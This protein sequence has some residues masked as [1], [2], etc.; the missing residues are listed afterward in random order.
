MPSVPTVAFVQSVLPE[1]NQTGAKPLLEY[2][3]GLDVSP[4]MFGGQVGQTLARAGDMLARNAAA[5]QALANET[6]VN[7][8][9]SNGFS[10]AFRQLRENFLKLEGKDA[11]AQFPSY[12]QQAN[13]LSQQYR[14]SLS[15]D[16][17]RKLFDREATRRVQMELDG[18]ARY[19]ADQTKQYEW[20]TYRAGISELT[21]HFMSLRDTPNNEKGS[22]HSRGRRKLQRSA[23]FK[24]RAGALGR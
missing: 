9:Y 6:M 7:D 4:A 10:P 14:D 13:Q 19:A 15:N 17:Q 11:E 23:A 20:N 18:M 12:E 1:R 21:Q 8:V 24:R 22:F 5:R 3:A 2:Y 16:M